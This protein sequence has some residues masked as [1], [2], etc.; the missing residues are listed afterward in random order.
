MF[1]DRQGGWMGGVG[2]MRPH[3]RQTGGY[4]SSGINPGGQHGLSQFFRLG[5]MSQG[6]PQMPAPYGQ[7]QGGYDSSGINPG[8]MYTGGNQFPANPGG[9]VPMGQMRPQGLAG[10]L[11]G[12]RQPNLRR[13]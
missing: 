12:F 13:Y 4:D 3:A 5:R 9:F 2:L 8:G 1:Y 11:A 6:Y 7:S 10:M